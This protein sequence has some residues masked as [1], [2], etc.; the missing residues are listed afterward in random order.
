MCWLL[1]SHLFSTSTASPRCYCPVLTITSEKN[2][3]SNFIC[4]ISM[5]TFWPC[6]HV[7]RLWSMSIHF[8]LFERAFWVHHGFNYNM[9]IKN[10]FSKKR[11]HRL[12]PAAPS[13]I[14]YNTIHRVL[15]QINGS[16]RIHSRLR[17][18]FFSFV[19]SAPMICSL[20]IHFFDCI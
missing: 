10:V 11:E 9:S 5:H 20:L 14:I 16:T 8:H 2:S 12:C 6:F 7:V 13:F 3:F 18:L 17:T 1:F 4:F 15:D 19:Q